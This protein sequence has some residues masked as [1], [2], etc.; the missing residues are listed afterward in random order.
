LPPPQQHHQSETNESQSINLRLDMAFPHLRITIVQQHNASDNN[1]AEADN[2]RHEDRLSIAKHVLHRKRKRHARNDDDDDNDDN[3]DSDDSD[4]SDDQPQPQPRIAQISNQPHQQLA[5]ATA[6]TEVSG[7]VAGSVSTIEL[8][9]VAPAPSRDQHNNWQPVAS[10][11]LL[12]DASL[13][14]IMQSYAQRIVRGG[15]TVTAT[16][17]TGGALSLQAN[18]SQLLDG[19]CGAGSRAWRSVAQL[20]IM[21]STSRHLKV[22]FDTETRDGA[23]SFGA[24][25]W[26]VDQ[27]QSPQSRVILN[28]GPAERILDVERAAWGAS[29][30]IRQTIAIPVLGICVMESGYRHTV[31]HRAS[32]PSHSTTAAL[33]FDIGKSTTLDDVRVGAERLYASLRSTVAET[34]L[35]SVIQHDMGVAELC[36]AIS[37][38]SFEKYT[39]LVGR[40]GEK[41]IKHLLDS[42]L[43]DD[44]T[45]RALALWR[46]ELLRCQPLRSQAV[47]LGLAV[48]L[49]VELANDASWHGATATKA[50]CKHDPPPA[51]IRVERIKPARRFAKVAIK[52]AHVAQQM[53]DGTAVAEHDDA[54]EGDE[55]DEDNEDDES[56]DSDDNH[57]ETTA[58]ESSDSDLLWTISAHLRTAID[59]ARSKMPPT[60]SPPTDA[61]Y[62]DFTQRMLAR[63][64][65]LAHANSIAPLPRTL[66]LALHHY[67]SCVVKDSNDASTLL[68]HIDKRATQRNQHYSDAH[69]LAQ[70]ARNAIRRADPDANSATPVDAVAVASAVAADPESLW[71]TLRS[72]AATVALINSLGLS[73]LLRNSRMKGSL[74]RARSGWLRDAA[75]NIQSLRAVDKY[76]NELYR[77]LFYGLK[78]FHFRSLNESSVRQLKGRFSHY[79]SIDIARQ[80]V[81]GAKQLQQSETNLQ[82]NTFVGHLEQMMQRFEEANAQLEPYHKNKNKK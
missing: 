14:Q 41:A 56:T 16:T 70:R 52:F 63:S 22:L 58:N 13:M 46:I 28:L 2:R 11:L 25:D 24:T 51:D 57:H 34:S 73:E 49:L 80:I 36:T 35:Q 69:F 39:S 12:G 64:K 40:H 44:P 17:T 66:F 47:K 33:I 43:S 6:Y 65:T 68:E 32:A 62:V 38:G 31:R 81:N 4:D 7:T 45:M 53:L 8:W 1:D 54:D 5:V 79:I 82:L 9:L 20:S 37:S 19:L 10:S 55:D 72:N 67:L 21:T 48:Q 42:L 23:A 26:H 76:N 18:D 3:D 27:G 71:E 78:K 29:P 75:G 60:L 15:S 30:A 74:E 77:S 59:L 61:Q 50:I